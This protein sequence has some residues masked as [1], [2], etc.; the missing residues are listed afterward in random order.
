VTVIDF[1]EEGTTINSQRTGTPARTRVA[2]TQEAL[3]RLPFKEVLPHPPYTPNFVLCDFHLFPKM[4][5]HLKGH[6]IHSDDK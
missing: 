1:L 3:Q 5:E 4:K 6:H 2:K